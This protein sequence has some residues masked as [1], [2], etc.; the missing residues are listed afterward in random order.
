MSAQISDDSWK[1]KFPKVKLEFKKA[2]LTWTDENGEE[3]T[4]DETSGKWQNANSQSLDQNPELELEKNNIKL[5]PKTG[6]V[7][8]SFENGNKL[9]IS[10][11]HNPEL[12]N[13]K[14]SNYVAG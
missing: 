3:F 7:E 8:I 6:E 2:K 9:I 10:N 12:S 13:S 1:L 5:K 11:T 4:W 14:L